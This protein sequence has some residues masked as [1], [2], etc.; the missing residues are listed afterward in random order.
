MAGR[1]YYLITEPQQKDNLLFNY[2]SLLLEKP[3]LLLPVISS[4][5][6]TKYGGRVISLKKEDILFQVGDQPL[7]YFELVSG[8]IKM[9]TYSEDGDEFI[10]GI[11]NPGESFG[12]PPLMSGFDYPSSAIA[13]APSE[14]WKLPKE[15]FFNL[16]KENF[17]VHLD[18]DKVL[19]ERLRYKNMILSEIS[20]YDPEHRIVSLINYLK[21][22]LGNSQ[23]K[24]IVPLTRQQLA[25]MSG[26]RVE[27]V[28]RTVKTMEEQG[29]LN[30]VDHK[31][32]I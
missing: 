30:I 25:D 6:L 3:N 29:K 1:H 27:T 24:F 19:C 23:E 31:I 16:L 5:L 15:N 12:E 9:V 7:N 20:F 32:Q 4:E 17:Q 11:F 22:K 21:E 26:L 13:L 18:F 10:Q 14:V 2:L 8:S 28:I